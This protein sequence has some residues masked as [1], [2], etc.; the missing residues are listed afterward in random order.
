MNKDVLITIQTKGT[1]NCGIDGYRLEDKDGL[2]VYEVISIPELS[3]FKVIN[4]NTKNKRAVIFLQVEGF[5]SEVAEVSYA[6]L[7]DHA[8]LN[9][10]DAT[11]SVEAILISDRV[12]YRL[13]KESVRTVVT[14]II[15]A[16]LSFLI[17]RV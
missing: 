10:I 1:F 5:T 4:F 11:K 12:K 14:Y 15:L 8:T 9:N 13:S 16:V 3:T 7:I 2:K 17:G 6:S